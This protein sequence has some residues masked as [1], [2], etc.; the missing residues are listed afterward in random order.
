MLPSLKLTARTCQEAETQKETHFATPVF[1]GE[2]PQASCFCT[3]RVGFSPPREV[4]LR[5]NISQK[6]LVVWFVDFVECTGMF[7][8]LCPEF[9]QP[10]IFYKRSSCGFSGKEWVSCQDRTL[11]LVEWQLS[12]PWI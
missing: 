8:Q 9:L 1:Q 3:L 12:V 5:E 7:K 10:S 6:Q 11:V 2:V 4:I